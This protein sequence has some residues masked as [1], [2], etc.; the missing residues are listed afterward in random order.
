MRRRGNRSAN[1]SRQVNI[2]GCLV[3]EEPRLS[4]SGPIS[5]N[6]IRMTGGG[7][8]GRSASEANGYWNKIHLPP[9]LFELRMMVITMQ[10]DEG[11]AHDCELQPWSRILLQLRNRSCQ[12]VPGLR[13]RRTYAGCR[14][15]PSLRRFHMSAALWRRHDNSLDA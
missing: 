4:G 14:A 12:R 7:H 13:R 10:L 11:Q 5:A 1:T 6:A 8:H 3:A 9:P 15:F 2:W